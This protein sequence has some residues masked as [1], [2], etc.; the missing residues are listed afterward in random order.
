M[1][2]FRTEDGISDRLVE[3]LLEAW[4]PTYQSPPETVWPLKMMSDMSGLVP[5]IDTFSASS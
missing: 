4:S 1:A 3:R 2:W 5:R